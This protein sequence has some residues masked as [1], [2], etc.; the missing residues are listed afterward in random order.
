MD[1]R[2]FKIFIVSEYNNDHIFEVEML[3]SKE[4]HHF[5][6]ARILQM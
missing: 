3:N 5:L 2:E 1:L 4:T 6:G